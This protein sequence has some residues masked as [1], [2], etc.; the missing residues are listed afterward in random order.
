MIYPVE[1]A[2]EYAQSINEYHERHGVKEI[3]WL[4]DYWKHLAISR[5]FEIWK[6]GDAATVRRG[7]LAVG[8]FT[9]SIGAIIGANQNLEERGLSGPLESYARKGKRIWY[10]HD[11]MRL[12]SDEIPELPSEGI[13]CARE[14]AKKLNNG[15]GA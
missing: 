10:I 15:N 11:K 4:Q 2:Q 3:Y 12:Y 1:Y 8:H 7:L 14:L 13:E 6:R 5:Y 9:K